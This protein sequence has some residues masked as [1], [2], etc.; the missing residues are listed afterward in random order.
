MQKDL[1]KMG[2][3]WIMNT[4]PEKP[5]DNYYC[6]TRDIFQAKLDKMINDLI[7]GKKN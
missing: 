1:Q 7:R 4:I 3:Q 5:K 6:E 2:F